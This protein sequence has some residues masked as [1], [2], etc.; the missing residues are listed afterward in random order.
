MNQHGL[1]D[2]MRIFYK[3]GMSTRYILGFGL[4]CTY[5]LYYAISKHNQ[6]KKDISIFGALKTY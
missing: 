2:L 4:S 5:G 1:L 3:Q 6:Y